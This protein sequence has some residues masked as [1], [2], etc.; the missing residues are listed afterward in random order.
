MSNET[1]LCIDMRGAAHNLTHHIENLKVLRENEREQSFGKGTTDA[2]A[3][4]SCL[5]E[6][7]E[8][9]SGVFQGDEPRI[10]SSYR[11]LGE[12]ALHPNECMHF[13][14]TQY[15][16]R[17]AWNSA[18]TNPFQW[19]PAPLDEDAE[20]EWT[21]VRSLI[22]DAVRYLPTAYCYYGYEG[23]D[24]QC[25]RADSNGNVCTFLLAGG[26]LNFPGEMQGRFQLDAV[27]TFQQNL[28][29]PGTSTVD[30]TLIVP[31][32]TPEG[33]RSNTLQVGVNAS[34]LCPAGS[35]PMEFIFPSAALQR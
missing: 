9:Y 2:Q 33:E 18:N 23:P 30:V 19:V 31:D 17:E 35:A 14:P 28:A 12:A 20:T 7:L 10:R 24:L 26:P 16:R 5:G 13:S 6:A 21:P 34:P 3:R 22:D 8:R 25:C 4:A 27:P 29:E 11:A 15:A 32:G 1:C